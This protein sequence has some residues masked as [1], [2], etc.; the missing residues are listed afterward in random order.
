MSKFLAL[1]ERRRM[2]RD[3][4]SHYRDGLIVQR[5]G[6]PR[7]VVGVCE[8]WR[9]GPRTAMAAFY[10]GDPVEPDKLLAEIQKCIAENTIRDQDAPLKAAACWVIREW[11][12][13]TAARELRRANEIFRDAIEGADIDNDEAARLR[14]TVE[15]AL[16]TT[17]DA[18]VTHGS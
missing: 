4:R 1:R 7:T 16:P 13:A 9:D 12:L 15:R 17:D 3:W 5:P 2:D 8:E 10:R 18:R 14:E 11:K 6:T